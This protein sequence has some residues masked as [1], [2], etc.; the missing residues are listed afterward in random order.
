M[1]IAIT[2]QLKISASLTQ[3]RMNRY[4]QKII[5]IILQQ[6]NNVIV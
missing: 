5:A 4:M 2:K 1:I 6:N 3:Q